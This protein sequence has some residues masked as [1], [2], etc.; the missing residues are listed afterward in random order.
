MLHCPIADYF[1]SQGASDLCVGTWCNLDFA[2]AEMWGGR[3]ERHETLSAG[4]ARCD[5]RFKGGP[6]IVTDTREM[7]T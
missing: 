3:L 5:F 6:A 1:E 2:L 4:C 7:P